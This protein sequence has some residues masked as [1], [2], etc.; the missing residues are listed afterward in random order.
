MIPVNAR[1]SIRA[2]GVHSCGG[3]GNVL[4]CH[5]IAIRYVVEPSG[6]SVAAGGKRYE[7]LVLRSCSLLAIL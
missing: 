1:S 4:K 5:L 3:M 6:A 7:G 2:D